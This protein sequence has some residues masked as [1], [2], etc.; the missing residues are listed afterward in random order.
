MNYIDIAIAAYFP[1][2]YV[3]FF[4]ATRRFDGRKYGEKINIYENNPTRKDYENYSW[5][6]GRR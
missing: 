1:L 4:S 6:F 2:V 3:E 5:L